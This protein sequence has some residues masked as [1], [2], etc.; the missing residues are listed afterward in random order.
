MPGK[1]SPPL[2]EVRDSPIHGRGGF[3]LQHI[4][5]GTRIVEYLGERVSSAEADARYEQADKADQPHVLLFT[6]DK[7][8]VIDAG[9]NGNEARFIN[10][11]CEPNC[12]IVVERKRVFIEARRDMRAGEEITY[13]Y[14]L[15]REG[16]DD[17]ETERRF[18][19]RC[20]AS[21]CRGT[22]LI[23]KKGSKG[24]PRG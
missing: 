15:E 2:F 6:V 9:V 8:T 20:G 16:D 14:A 10:H 22:M 24:R 3:A 19:C 12:E 18:A 13:D 21:T 4:A 11:A 7:H 1:P 5:A 23:A 17:E